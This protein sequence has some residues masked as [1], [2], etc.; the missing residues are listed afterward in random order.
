MKGSLSDRSCCRGFMSATITEVKRREKKEE[1]TKVSEHEH[2]DGS[3]G[4][5]EARAPI[6]LMDHSNDVSMVVEH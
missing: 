3:F 1:R 2:L 5:R 4:W 6:V